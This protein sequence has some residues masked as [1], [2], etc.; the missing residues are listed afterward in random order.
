MKQIENKVVE[1]MKRYTFNEEVW[2]NYNLDT[3]IINDL[4]INSAR[5]VDIVLDI[6]EEFGIELEDESIGKLITIRDV[7]EQIK[8]K[9][10]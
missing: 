4:K 9:S 7:I 3:K 10:K 6:E 2:D 1:I 8:E 5:I